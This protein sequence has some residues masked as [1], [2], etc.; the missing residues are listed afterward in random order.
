MSSGL[1]NKLTGQIGEYLVCAELGRRGFIA[2]P[3]SGNVP[4]FDVLAT[5]EFC[6]TVPIQVKASNSDNWPATARDWMNIHLDSESGVQTL[7]GLVKIPNP[8][9]IYVCISIAKVNSGKN[10]RYF[11]LTKTDVQQA[12]VKGYSAWMEKHNWKRPR[13]PASFDSRY[14]IPTIEHFENNWDLIASR[15]E[16]TSPSASMENLDEPSE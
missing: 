12:I 5:D 1:G 3:F 16:A 11:V 7:L 15:I 4:A 6:R 2:T 10:D 14:F 13:N 8:D 9:L